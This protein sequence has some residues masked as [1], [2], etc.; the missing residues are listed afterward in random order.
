MSE[1]FKAIY[2]ILSILQK[3]MD[4]EEPDMKKI[5]AEN[6]GITRTVLGMARFLLCPKHGV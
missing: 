1:D 2:K 6:L 5:S 4:F 3:S